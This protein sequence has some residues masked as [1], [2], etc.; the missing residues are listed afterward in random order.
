MKADNERG[1]VDIAV[2]Y[3]NTCR[4][5]C[6]P[7]DDPTVHL[8]ALENDAFAMGICGARPLLNDV[9]KQGIRGLAVPAPNQTP[10]PVETGGGGRLGVTSPRRLRTTPCTRREQVVV[11]ARAGLVDERH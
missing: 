6:W 7:C 11:V 8:K 5:A 2:S 9:R 3:P 4:F 1:V 10:P